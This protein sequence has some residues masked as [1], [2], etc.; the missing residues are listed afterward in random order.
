MGR[1]DTGCGR[2]PLPLVRASSLPYF[3]RAVFSPLQIWNHLRVKM[4]DYNPGDLV[5]WRILR[6]WKDSD[7]LERNA[8]YDLEPASWSN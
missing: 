5:A 4:A 7:C 3:S 8:K 6:A 1:L 2:D